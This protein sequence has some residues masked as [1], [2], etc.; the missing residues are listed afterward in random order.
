MYWLD[1]P[2][3]LFDLRA[4]TEEFRDL[5][6]NPTTEGVRIGLRDKLL[7]F[8]ARRRHRATVTDAA[9]ERGT[10]ACKQAGVY[11]GQW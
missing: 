5:G 6:R 4:D 2:E 11:F 9:V 10:N 7:S 3:Q 1:E 8:L